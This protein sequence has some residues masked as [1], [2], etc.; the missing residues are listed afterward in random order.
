MKDAAQ[1]VAEDVTQ[2]VAEDVLGVADHH[3][4]R[5]LPSTAPNP[6]PPKVSSS[7]VSS[8]SRALWT[9]EALVGAAG[10][11]TVAVDT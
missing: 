4:A 8:S 1:D 5:S 9:F 6:T 7:A 3:H 11:V 10:Q 2:D